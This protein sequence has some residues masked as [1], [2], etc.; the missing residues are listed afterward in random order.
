MPVTAL[1]NG[2]I[3]RLLEDPNKDTVTRGGLIVMANNE[4][5]NG[6][7]PRWFQTISV[8]KEI[9]YIKEG[10]YILVAHG[11]WTRGLD[12]DGEKV[13]G[14][15]VPEIMGTSDTLPADIG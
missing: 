9:D 12:V 3:A 8:G 7:R 2:I 11:R 10:E 14:I 13:F 6:I 1:P 5:E 15:D 4:S